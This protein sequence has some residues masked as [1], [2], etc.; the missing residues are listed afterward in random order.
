MWRF[1]FL[2]A[3]RNL[4]SRN[5]V[6]RVLGQGRIYV[7]TERMAFSLSKVAKRACTAILS[8]L[9]RPS[10]SRRVRLQVRIMRSRRAPGAWVYGPSAKKEYPLVL[11][12]KLSLKFLGRLSAKRFPFPAIESYNSQAFSRS[13]LI[14]DLKASNASVSPSMQT[15]V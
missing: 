5:S 12:N 15:W 10:P 9:K 6:I 3:F 4:W 13:R 11:S 1:L 8:Q 7:S 2:E 14:P